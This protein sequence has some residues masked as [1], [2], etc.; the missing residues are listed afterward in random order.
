MLNA[1]TSHA[2]AQ[3]VALADVYE[4]YLQGE[5]DKIDPRF[6]SLGR[7]VPKKQPNFGGDVA[8][9]K[10]FRRLLDRKD[11]DAVIIATPDHWHA[12]QTIMACDA[13]KDVYVEKPLSIVIK[14]GRRMVEAA[15]RNDRVVQVGT[16][17]R[18]SKLYA[19]LAEML[20]SGAI[21]KIT[22][23]RACYVANLAP[24]GIGRERD[25]EPPAGFDWEM[26]LGP[27]PSRPFRADIAPYKF[28][29]WALYSSQIAN[30]GIHYRDALRWLT[31]ETAP[32]SV[33]AHGGIFAVK[34]DRDIPDTAEVIFEHASGMLTLFS[35]YEANGQSTV[36]DGEIEIRGTN[37]TVFAGMSRFEIVPETGGQF[38]N[39]KPR[40]ER[41]VVTAKEIGYSSLDRDHAREFLDCVKSRRRPNA[42]VEEG[43]RS[44]TMALLANLSLATKARL[45]WDH[46]SERVVNVEAA[47]AH[48]DYE[49]RSPWKR[50]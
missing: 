32:A 35:V 34:D 30:L 25:S 4:P 45:D 18:S 15:R 14:E 20:H 23:A 10:D 42:D 5:Y 43:Q 12:I 36:R 21:G 1:F 13:G 24:D 46:E 44:T 3:I 16:Q 19:K 41:L 2:D 39:P 22:S 37:G 40:R 7:Q 50:V 48:L 17:R 28:R 31:G 11:I 47:N 38:Q 9:E 27:R 26:W 8:R 49:Y 29:W 33:S 6:K